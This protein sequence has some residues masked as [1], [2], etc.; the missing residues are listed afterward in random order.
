MIIIHGSQDPQ[1]GIAFSQ[2]DDKYY[3]GIP[4]DDLD[5]WFDA[6]PRETFL[7]YVKG[8]EYYA[9]YN[10][11]ISENKYV[12][13]LEINENL[14]EE[15]YDGEFFTGVLHRYVDGVRKDDQRLSLDS[16]D[17]PTIFYVVVGCDI[18]RFLKRGGG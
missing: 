15:D 17:V 6:L 5:Q 13:V 14:F 1:G 11:I 9:M 8:D 12:V 10:R 2:V 4:T 16:I 18:T 7:E 3:S